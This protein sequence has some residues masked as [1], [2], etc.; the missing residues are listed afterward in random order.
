MMHPP[1][2]AYWRQPA[3][4]G[5][6]LRHD[7]AP[8][9]PAAA[10]RGVERRPARPLSRLRRPARPDP[11][12]RPG[13][14]DSGPA[15]G[16][17]RHPQ[18]ADR[19]GQVAGRVRAALRVAR[20]GAALGLH[21]P[22]QGAGQ[23]E[24]DGPVPRVRAR[25]RGARHRRRHR[26]PRRP[27]AV[28]H[29]R[30]P[31]QHRP[32]RGGGGGGGRR[33][34]GRVPLVR[35]PRPRRGVAGAA[36]DPAADA[37][38][39]DVGDARR[40]VVLRAGAHAAHR[41]GDGDRHLERAAGAAR[42]RLLRGA[43]REGGGAAGRGGP[44]PRLRGP[45]HA[46]GRRRERPE[47]HE[48]AD[49]DARGEEG[50]GRGRRGRA[51][52]D[53][54]RP[55]RPHLAEARHRHP[56]RGPAAALPRARRAARP[57]GPAQGGLRHRHAGG[58]GQRAHP[59]RA[60][61]PPLEVRRREDGG[62]LGPRLPPDRGARRA[63][64]LRRARLGGGPG[65]R[66]RH[67]EPAARREGEG[68]QEGGAPP[69]AARQ[70]RALGRGDV[71]AARALAPGTAQVALR[72]LARHAAQ[73]AVAPRRRLRG[74]AP[75]R[76]RQPRDGRRQ[77]RAPAPRLAALP[78]AGGAQGRRDRA[79]HPR[80][81]AA[82][83]ERR[84]PGRL[85]DGPG[86]V[87]LPHRDHPAARP[88]R[89]DPRPRSAHARG[90]HP[91]EPGRDPVPAARQAEGGGGGGD[92]G[93]RHGLRRAHG[94]AREARAPQ[95]AGRL[96]LRDVQRLRRPAPVGGRGEHPP[97]V[98]RARDVRDLALVRRLRP[99]VR[100]RTHGGAA[101]PAPRER[102][103]GAAADGA[104]RRED[105]GGG[106]DGAL[107]PGP[108]AP[109]R[110]EP[111]RGVGADARPRLPARARGRGGA[112]RA[113]PRR[114]G[115]RDA[116]RA[117]LHRRH[118]RARFRAAARVVDRRRRGRA[119][120][121]RQRARRG[122]R[123]VDGASGWPRRAR[124]SRPRT[125]ACASTP[126]AATGGTPTPSRRTTARRGE[127]SRCWWTR[128]GTTTVAERRSTWPRSPP[129]RSCGCAAGARRGRAWVMRLL[130]LESL[131]P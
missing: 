23:R 62:A 4:W 57:A 113:R 75:A 35:R 61:Q 33:G 83:G 72:G 97:Q 19:L 124:R 56:P 26:Q 79:A 67:R 21:V 53:A 71:R 86:A 5:D 98:D 20:P 40:R 89:R 41:P 45:L 2:K 18:H 120:G 8:V 84:S 85:L 127:W 115:R 94:R 6:N 108:R 80:G 92:E 52:L 10:R 34:D 126:R 90:E 1:V 58:R 24:V 32:P 122:R 93:G 110:L 112:G 131:A 42:V 95:A 104:R 44:G 51:L 55:P 69:A 82:S 121:P 88:R 39:A 11:L 7:R 117:R 68:R 65:P 50:A 74:D 9:R 116:R 129:S 105:R 59:H 81:L 123:G 99:G 28:L 111:A 118:P 78:V 13:G 128:R 22:H 25:E 46:E 16:P 100:P 54:L 101:A 102:L 106:G 14:G 76:G 96:R 60:L 103:Q 3:H 12:S 36:A 49:R 30:D 47:L 114:A 27:G 73:R 29:G 109:G 119:R 38:P 66:A 63:Q 70:L 77:A 15:R 17:A 125:A 107:S 31:R 91:R 37:L 87:A 130:R 64:G 43:A 48:P